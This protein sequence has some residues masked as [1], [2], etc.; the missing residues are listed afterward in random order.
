MH[1]HGLLFSHLVMV[2]SPF[3]ISKM[4][5]QPPVGND[6]RFCSVPLA[7]C[8]VFF[9]YSMCTRKSVKRKMEYFASERTV[10]AR[11][12]AKDAIFIC[13][14]LSSL[15]AKPD[16]RHSDDRDKNLQMRILYRK[17]S[18]DDIICLM[19]S[20]FWS[21]IFL[22]RDFIKRCLFRVWLFAIAMGFFNWTLP[23]YCRSEIFHIMLNT[24]KGHELR[25][26]QNAGPTGRLPIWNLELRQS[27]IIF[28]Q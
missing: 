22:S 1:G 23:L 19:I 9:H 20:K 8:G 18:C 11:G 6:D 13:C 24:M 26:M 10:K 21:R 17:T 28:P 15:S 12:V 25:P 27:R 3:L 14:S 5:F 16:C 7:I 2:L 4:F